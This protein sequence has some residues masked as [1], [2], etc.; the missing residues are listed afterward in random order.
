MK[1]NLNAFNLES[2]TVMLFDVFFQYMR[3]NSQSES[4]NIAVSFKTV[5]T[6]SVTRPRVPRHNTRPARTRQRPTFSVSDRSFL[7]NL[8]IKI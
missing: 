4:D 2:I 1:K 5:I 6:T 8:I 7:T 3:L